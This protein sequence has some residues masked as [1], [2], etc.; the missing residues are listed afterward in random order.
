MKVSKFTALAALC[1]GSLCFHSP[2]ANAQED[3]PPPPPP[4]EAPAAT[5]SVSGPP[6][7]PASLAPGGGGGA[8]RMEQFRQ[9]MNEHVKTALKASDEEWAVIQPLLNN[10][11]DKMRETM[12]GRFGGG[13]RPERG[14]GGPRENG[15]NGGGGERPERAERPNRPDRPPSATSAPVEALRTALEST[16]T[17]NT[18]I[19]AKLEALRQSRQKAVDDLAKART[20]LKSVLSLRQEATLVMM[21]MLD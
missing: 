18:E 5:P 19:K 20:E 1:A 4:P 7:N 16:S 8:D 15:Q 21:G 6:P 10:V 17:S 11:Q 9:R 2:R 13:P 12:L 3:G 14:G